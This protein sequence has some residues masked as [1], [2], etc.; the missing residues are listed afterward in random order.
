MSQEPTELSSM[1]CLNVQSDEGRRGESQPSAG[2]G[3]AESL[4]RRLLQQQ[5]RQTELLEQLLL[6]QQSAQQQRQRELEQWKS[7]HPR[8]SRACRR[9]AE[10][11]SRVQAQFL[12]DLTDQVDAQEDALMA[13]DFMLT[14]FVDR[15]GPRLAHL[16][17]VVQVLAQLGHN[18]AD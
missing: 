3:E 14:E 18:P 7:A 4:L 1:F 8:L 16:N 2:R 17:G 15:F 13:G 9:A 10:S 6:Q 12:E 5:E 11:L